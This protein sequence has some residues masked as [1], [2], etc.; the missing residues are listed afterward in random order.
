MISLYFT[1]IHFINKTFDRQRQP[2]DQSSF[3][4]L[5]W[6]GTEC[7]GQVSG[8]W[9]VTFN[10]EKSPPDPGCSQASG[11]FKTRKQGFLLASTNDQKQ[12]SPGNV[13][14]IRQWEGQID[15]GDPTGDW[16]HEFKPSCLSLW[17]ADTKSGSHT[18]LREDK[19][20]NFT[21]VWD[22]RCENMMGTWGVE[23]NIFHCES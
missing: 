22:L 23:G 19:A 7:A 14:K 18:R 17:W 20:N 3:W 1:W 15:V 2:V 6:A 21:S 11:W 5:G 9:P 4:L 8:G 10:D 13:N 12:A 16:E